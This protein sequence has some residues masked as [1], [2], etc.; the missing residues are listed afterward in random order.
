MSKLEMEKLEERSKKH[1]EETARV[2]KLLSTNGTYAK[3]SRGF[4]HV[5][6]AENRIVLQSFK[7]GGKDCMRN[8]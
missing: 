8:K 4:E 5:D 6:C 1:A 2:G 3:T 7:W